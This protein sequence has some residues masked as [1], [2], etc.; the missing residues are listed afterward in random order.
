MFSRG[1]CDSLAYTYCQHTILMTLWGNMLDYNREIYIVKYVLYTE[2]RI[3]IIV[4]V[5]LS[6]VKRYR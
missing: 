1:D 3:F 6:D 2:K 5:R 4:E